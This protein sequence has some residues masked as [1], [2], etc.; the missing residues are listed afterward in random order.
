MSGHYSSTKFCNHFLL[1]GLILNI[2]DT[3]LNLPQ[4]SPLHAFLLTPTLPSSS[5]CFSLPQLHPPYFPFLSLFLFITYLHLI[6]FHALCKGVMN[7]VLTVTSPTWGEYVCDIKAVCVAPLPQGPY[8]L[9]KGT[10][11]YN[12]AL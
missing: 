7:E 8:V 4:F 12:L 9:Y 5:F 1:L 6:D 10:L 3:P 11:H 2:Y